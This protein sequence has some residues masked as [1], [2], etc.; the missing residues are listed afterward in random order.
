MLKTLL[1][2]G[3][4]YGGALALLALL[5]Q[6]AEYRY[7]ALTMPG[8]AYIAVV[9]L[10]FV[11]LGIWA[12]MRLTARPRGAGFERNDKAIASLGLTAR[13]YEILEHLARGSSNKE[14]ARSLD[15]SPNTIKTHIA[16]LYAKLDVSGRG[17]AVEAARALE[18][19]P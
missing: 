17:K 15:V 4:L 1:R 6:W 10:V 13:E 2:Y 12:G 7:F 3:L 9:A 16:N 5:L 14:I 18:L 11:S 8:E 19:I